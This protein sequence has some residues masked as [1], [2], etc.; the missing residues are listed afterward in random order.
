MDGSLLFHIP[1]GVALLNVVLP[2]GQSTNEPV[3]A[4]GN[5]MTVTAI[6]E[7]HPVGN[8]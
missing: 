1:P 2:A 5:A 7:K 6:V 8:V 3:I 4:A